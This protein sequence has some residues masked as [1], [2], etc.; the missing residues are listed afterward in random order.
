M[1]G[2]DQGC[3]LSDDGDDCDAYARKKS[4]R[5]VMEFEG[6]KNV[7]RG[8]SSEYVRRN[9][10]NWFDMERIKSVYCG[11]RSHSL[12]AYQ[13]RRYIAWIFVFIFSTKI[14]FIDHPEQGTR[15]LVN[16]REVRKR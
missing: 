7:C 12:S 16:S 6:A 14:T 13:R 8:F 2:I 10:V 5:I 3:W 11:S 1:A 9:L 4:S 15:S